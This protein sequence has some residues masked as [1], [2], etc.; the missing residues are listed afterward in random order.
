MRTQAVRAERL[1]AFHRGRP[2]KR[3]RYVGVY[4]PQL[5]LCAGRVTIAGVPQRFWAVWEPGRPGLRELTALGAPAGRLRLD[6]DRVQVREHG[7]EL[8]L[9]LEPAGVPVRVRSPHGRAWIWTQKRPVRAIGRVLIDGRRVDLDAP[10]LVDDSAGYHASETEW[11]WAAGAG[12]DVDGR[13]VVWNLVDGVHDLPEASERRVWVDGVPHEVGAVSF[14]TDLAGVTFA[15]GGGL[16]F[17]AGATRERH[18]RMLGGL[19]RSDYV[20][21]F[22]TVA[23][24]LPGGVRLA[25]GVGVMEHHRAR[26]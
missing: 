8:D 16:T 13:A 3:W 11:R 15:E 14:A 5:A 22:G 18:E 17:T 25:A 12:E 7:V 2:L 21:P 19:L 26:W 23:G 24:V 1:P 20:Q 4:A 10:G 6:A 9:R